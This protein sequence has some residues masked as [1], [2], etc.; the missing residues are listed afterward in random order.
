ML[1]LWIDGA[2]RKNGKP[3]CIAVG[4]V[5][6]IAE[7]RSFICTV[8]EECSTN[9]RGELKALILALQQAKIA[10]FNGEQHFVIVTDSEHIYNTIHKEWYINWEIKGWI[11][12]TGAPVKNKDCW[13]EI[14]GYLRLL[15]DADIAVFHIKGHALTVGLGKKAR[16]S[17]IEK[18]PS[19]MTLYHKYEEMFKDMPENKLLDFEICFEKNHGYYPE[20]AVLEKL[21][22]GNMVADAIATYQ[23]DKIYNCTM[24]E[25]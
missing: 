5:F 10:Y 22:V 14:V 24:E 6:I 25:K 9:Q 17:I 1:K 16:E 19:C 7:D 21:I 3:D 15:S 12:S 13:M 20:R 2:S 23:I 11:T 8:C 4:G 18:D